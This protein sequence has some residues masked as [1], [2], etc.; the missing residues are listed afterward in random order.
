MVIVFVKK[1]KVKSDFSDNV[2][3][4]EDTLVIIAMVEQADLVN[5][6]DSV[7]HK[8]LHF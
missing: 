3:S 2:E 5:L 8:N 1:T 4:N 6:D 7:V